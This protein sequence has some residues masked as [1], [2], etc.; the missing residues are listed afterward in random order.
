[1]CC[2]H[3]HINVKTMDERKERG[4]KLKEEKQVSMQRDHCCRER[5]L[6]QLDRSANMNEIIRS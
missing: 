4:K 3:L 2:L 1:M 5:S 6:L